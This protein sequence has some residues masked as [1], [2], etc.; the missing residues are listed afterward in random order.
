MVVWIPEMRLSRGVPDL[1]PSEKGMVE[2][3]WPEQNRNLEEESLV[4][5]D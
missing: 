3:G 4:T 5:K 2:G 1:V